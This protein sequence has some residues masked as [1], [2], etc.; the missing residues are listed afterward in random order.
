M[1]SFS[2]ILS[3][4]KVKISKIQDGLEDEYE[5]EFDT[6]DPD[7][8]DVLPQKAVRKFSEAMIQARIDQITEVRDESY[9]RLTQE[10]DDFTTMLAEIQKLK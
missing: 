3:K 6:H 2:D 7:T 1:A 4:N 8:G 5:F 9:A 10:I